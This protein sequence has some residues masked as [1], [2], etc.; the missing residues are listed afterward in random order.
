MLIPTFLINFSKYP[1][2]ELDVNKPREVSF[3]LFASISREGL[4]LLMPLS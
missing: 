3:I 2:G 4:A 1:L